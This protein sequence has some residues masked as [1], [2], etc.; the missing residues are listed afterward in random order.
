MSNNYLNKYRNVNISFRSYLSTLSL[1]KNIGSNLVLLD[2]TKIF[3][4]LF[5]NFD[6]ISSKI[7]NPYLSKVTNNNEITSV[8]Q[9]RNL[10]SISKQY[11]FW[12]FENGNF[13]NNLLINDLTSIG[14]LDL[15][16]NDNYEVFKD[17]EYFDYEDGLDDDAF[18]T[19]EWYSDYT[20]GDMTDIYESDVEDEPDLLLSEEEF[21]ADL[22]L[23]P[24]VKDAYDVQGLAHSYLHLGGLIE[25]EDEID[26]DI[27]VENKFNVGKH[28]WEFRYSIYF[29]NFINLN[30]VYIRNFILKLLNH[31]KGVPISE[32]INTNQ[33]ADREEAVKWQT[34]YNF[35]NSESDD[36]GMFSFRS[37]YEKPIRQSKFNRIERL[38]DGNSK[39]LK[40]FFKELNVKNNFDLLIPKYLYTS[41]DFVDHLDYLVD[42]NNEEISDYSN[43]YDIYDMMLGVSTLNY[44]ES[45]RFSQNNFLITKMLA[46]YRFLLLY[47]N[48]Y[49][50][51]DG[52]YKRLVFISFFFFD[53]NILFFKLLKKVIGKNFL[54]YNLNRMVKFIYNSVYMYKYQQLKIYLQKKK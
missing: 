18:F 45:L 53:L 7:V 21:D 37:I 15:V 19:S 44:E 30:Y 4:Y 29:A 14:K 42:Y 13:I 12:Y 28:L 25:N 2:D 51:I 5:N 22:E 9:K 50:Y 46:Y 54:E 32:I 39:V 10:E 49:R 1:Y 38:L 35:Q 11:G 6:L 41:M 47:I 3:D 24:L 27:L 20:M 33:I 34:R 43:D 31:Y 8:F 16:F 40:T 36:F 23:D 52:L 26:I 17:G 48:V